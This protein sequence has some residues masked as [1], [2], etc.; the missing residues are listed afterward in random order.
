MIRLSEIQYALDKYDA[1]KGFFRIRHISDQKD[2]G[3]LR[4]FYNE[5]LTKNKDP[6]AFL[7]SKQVILVVK[8]LREGK[9]EANSASE[10][11]LQMLS[12]SL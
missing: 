2:I 11:A 1:E 6:E 5:A 7:D 12:K 4:E 3:K 10:Q 9:D 8:I